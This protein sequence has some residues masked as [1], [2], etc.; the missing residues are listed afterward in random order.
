LNAL[1]TEYG[2]SCPV[3]HRGLGF[4]A[5]LRPGQ[6]VAIEI[7]VTRLGDSSLI[8]RFAAFAPTTY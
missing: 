3:V 6:E 2:V 1:N 8:S 5:P 4:K 7:L